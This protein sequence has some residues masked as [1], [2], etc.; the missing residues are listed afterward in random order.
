MQSARPRKFGERSRHRW[1]SAADVVAGF[2]APST[3]ISAA[4]AVKGG[5]LTR[6]SF[7]AAFDLRSFRAAAT[8]FRALPPAPSKV[9]GFPLLP[10]TLDRM[11]RGT[12][13]SESELDDPALE[14]DHGGMGSVLGTQFGEDVAHLTLHGV[15]TQ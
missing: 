8:A 3:W 15:L 13:S 4:F 2:S 7:L 6:G 5:A 11:N 14:G 1:F 9:I 10:E 12:L